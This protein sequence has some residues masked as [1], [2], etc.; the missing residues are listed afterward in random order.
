[1]RSRVAPLLVLL[2]LCLLPSFSFA[3]WSI[4]G[5]MGTAYSI[6]MRLIIEQPGEETI[7]YTAHWDTKPLYDAPYYGWRIGRWE[8]GKAWEFELIHHK[9][10]L[11]NP[12]D[13]IQNF[14]VSHGYNLLTINRGWSDGPVI[15]RLGAG[16]VVAHPENEIRNQN[17]DTHEGLFNR[18][19]YF[20]GP[21]VQGSVGKRFPLFAGFFVN[22]EGK[23]SAAYARIPVAGD[24][25]ATVPNIAAHIVA[26]IG[27]ETN[28]G[29][30]RIEPI[31]PPISAR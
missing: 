1:M 24:G 29:A 5:Y 6:P 9:I 14:N 7:D 10:Y 18:G 12:T 22:L 26:G 13:E 3:G 2:S 21:C 31:A 28:G 16:A 8:E 17:F 20:A 15:L 27:F 4:E 23:L 25:H 19:F 11:T 30:D